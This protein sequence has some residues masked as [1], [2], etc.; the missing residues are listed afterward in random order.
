MDEER[1]DTPPIYQLR[2][3]VKML[4]QEMTDH[5]ELSHNRW[6]EHDNQLVLRNRLLIEE[7]VQRVG[8]EVRLQMK[9][10][11]ER[12]NLM[13]LFCNTEVR[14]TIVRGRLHQQWLM[15]LTGFIIAV[16]MTVIGL[17]L[18]KP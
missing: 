16:V 6:V 11:M 18:H 7:C 15:G 4:Q 2:E 3:V 8:A 10:V 17:W 12:M 9:D 1:H 13:E 14:P 5:K